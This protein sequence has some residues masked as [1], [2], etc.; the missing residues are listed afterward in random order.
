MFFKFN[1]VGFVG[2]WNVV[3]L[4]P[5]GFV[6]HFTEIEVFEIPTERQVIVLLVNGLIGTMLSE[7]LWLWYVMQSSCLA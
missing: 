5:V 4:W 3:L 7:A 2:L 1:Y 6:L